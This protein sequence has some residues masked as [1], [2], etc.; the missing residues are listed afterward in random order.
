MRAPMEPFATPQAAPFGSDC[1]IVVHY[2]SSLY[3][4]IFSIYNSVFA[5]NILQLVGIPGYL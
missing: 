4:T 3:F 5:L 1:R 2:N